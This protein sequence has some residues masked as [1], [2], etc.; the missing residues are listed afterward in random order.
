MPLYGEDVVNGAVF[1]SSAFRA[2][3]GSAARSATSGSGTAGS[4]SSRLPR[5]TNLPS[6]PYDLKSPANPHWDSFL[7][8]V[9]RQT[10]RDLADLRANGVD[11]PSISGMWD[12][13]VQTLS[14]GAALPST[15]GGGGGGGGGGEAGGG[16]GVGGATSGMYGGGEGGSSIDGGSGSFSSQPTIHST[17]FRSFFIDPA[18]NAA[19][20]TMFASFLQ[21]EAARP[22]PSRAAQGAGRQ[23]GPPLPAPPRGQG[24]RQGRRLMDR[25]FSRFAGSFSSSS[26]EPKQ[27]QPPPHNGQQQQH[28]Q[29]RQQQQKQQQQQQ[30]R[31]NPQRQ[32]RGYYQPQQQRRQHHNPPYHPNPKPAPQQRRR[33]APPAL[34]QKV[35]DLLSPSVLKTIM[36]RTSGSG[37]T[38]V[39]GSTSG[40]G[41]LTSRAASPAH[42]THWHPQ[43][44]GGYGSRSGS[45]SPS[46]WSS[47]PY[48]TGRSVRPT[49]G[50]PR[51]TF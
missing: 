35:Y 4:S 16:V 3:S 5:L 44:S 7:Q 12:V 29:Q 27:Q 11:D 24:E 23:P 25:M 48:S 46:P 49:A 19:G 45:W 8:E 28:R 32:P 47:S 26:S 17:W 10:S 39:S 51:W 15:R 36:S 9:A 20:K 13:Y 6:V 43:Q 41:S 42:R 33:P 50:A 30:P 22:A 40:S 18:D 34:V 38:S 37:R 14:D 2:F 31:Q 1:G 21:P